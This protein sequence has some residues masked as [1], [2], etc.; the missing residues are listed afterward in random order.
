MQLGERGLMVAS[1]FGTLLNEHGSTRNRIFACLREVFDGKFVRQL[2]TDGGRTFAWAG[3]AGFTGACTEA[4]DSPSIDLGLLGERFT[5]FRVPP[6]TAGEDYLACVVA[7]ENAGHQPRI[8]SDR[9][10][11]VAD[12]FDGLA[13]PAEL[14]PLSEE[15]QS[16]L[17]TLAGVGTKC[18]SSVVRDGYSREI[19]L[20]PNHER[21]P[22]LYSQ[23]RQLH[24]GFTVI[25][26]PE[27]DVWRL[28][29]K[30]A[31]DGIHPGRRAVLDY[32]MTWPGEH[33]TASIAGHCRLTVTPTRR[34][35]QDL[36]AHGV[37]DVV[38]ENPERWTTSD[39]LRDAWWAVA[40][41]SQPVGAS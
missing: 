5:Y 1:D 30:A 8:R 26:T 31:L 37:L 41:L 15:Q 28:L 34:H 40:D 11:L 19:E 22:R 32:L 12:F 27:V 6:V 7:D 4:I 21:S 20:V 33:T 24:A 9:A 3:H 18:R 14:P 16:R 36:C 2:G 29:A 13:L 39:W 17:I 10:R 38:G 25:G 23:L 35:L